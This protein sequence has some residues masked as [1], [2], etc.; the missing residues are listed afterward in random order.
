MPRKLKTFKMY[1]PTSV[2]L[3]RLL[4]RAEADRVPIVWLLEQLGRRSFGLTFFVMGVVAL[5]PGAS[6]STTT[7]L[8]RRGSR[9]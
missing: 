6:T 7:L 5:V 3:S 2:E 1:T 9:K 8:R 4:E